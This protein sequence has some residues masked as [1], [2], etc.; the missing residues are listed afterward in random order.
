MTSMW[1]RSR[2][3]LAAGLLAVAGS[4]CAGTAAQP[5]TAD[6]PPTHLVS[7]DPNPF[8]IGRPLV[9]PHSGGDAMF[10]ENTLYAYQHSMTLGG[11]V[12]DADVNLTADGIP[13][14]IHDSTLQRTTNGRGNVA[15]MTYAEI[16]TLDAGYNFTTGGTHPFRGKGL[17]IPTI[18]SLLVAFP[19]TLVTLDLKDLRTSAVPPL[20]SLLERLGRTRDVY[21]GVDTS[22][23]VAR[24]R[25]LCPEVRTSG[26]DADRQAMRLARTTGDASFTT[27]QLVSQPQFIRGDG[28]PRITSDSVAFSHKYDI[29][30][31]PWVVDD[32]AQLNDLI[33]LGVD[34]IY[35]RR[36]DVL[37]GLLRK[38]GLIS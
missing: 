13:V 37:V 2:R 24:F 6:V 9:I 38:D 15:D 12:V 33:R 21:I 11:E 16:A 8:R 32:P 7:A 31:L 5:P 25:Q 20:C 22:A 29:A 28:T 35:T 18:E 1:V 19:H 23:Q 27:H 17:N 14:A 36:P 10:P 4:A 34:G 3:L 30:V 26:T